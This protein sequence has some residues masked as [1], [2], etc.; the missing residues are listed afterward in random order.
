[1]RT[2]HGSRVATIR[3]ERL[4]AIFD[5]VDTVLVDIS[6]AVVMGEAAT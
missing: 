3:G 5:D 4:V 1:M 6:V 2:T